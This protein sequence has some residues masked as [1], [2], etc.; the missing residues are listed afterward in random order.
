MADEVGAEKVTP[1]LAGAVPDQI[2]GQVVSVCMA[3]GV[4]KEHAELVM[5]VL[6]ACSGESGG[7][8]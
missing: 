8:R 6:A 3:L 2:A 4:P 7:G 1:A 5:R